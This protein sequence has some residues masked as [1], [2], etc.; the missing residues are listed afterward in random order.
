MAP[1]AGHVKRRTLKTQQGLNRGMY[2]TR[3][4][5][6]QL[7]GRWA[8][9]KVSTRAEAQA[10]VEAEAQAEAQAAV[11][12]QH[13]PKEP[14]HSSVQALP[15]ARLPGGG[16]YGTVGRLCSGS[17]D[18]GTVHGFRSAQPAAHSAREVSLVFRFVFSS[19]NGG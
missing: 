7:E 18:H 1:S 13:S 14:K 11:G 17:L 12:R 10:A 15:G 4:H 2:P 3:H 16:T 6:H 5:T 8:G 19:R 9:A